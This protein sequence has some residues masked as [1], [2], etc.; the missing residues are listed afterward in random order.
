MIK[1]VKK[2]GRVKSALINWL[3][4]PIELTDDAF[5]RAFTANQ[6]A[7]G[8]TVNDKT[9]LSL[10]AAWACT[11]LIAET[12]STLPLKLYERTSTGRVEATGHS[13]H[14]IL[15][16]RPNSQSTPSTYWEASVAAMLLRGNSFSEKRY[17]GD[18]LVSLQYLQYGRLAPKNRDATVWVYTECDGK[19]RD[20]PASRLFHVP[21][22]SVDGRWGLSAI[23]YGA[24][25]FGSALA[26]SNAANSTFEKGLMP[27]VAFTLDRILKKEQRADF[28][29]SL[30]SM[31][32]ALNA[33]DSPLLEGG[34]DAKQIGIS[35]AD[36][37]LLESRAF[38]VEEVCRWFRV[39]PSM[40]G[41]GGKDSNWGTGLE[42]KVLA[43]LTFTL[44][45]WLTRIE[46]S[47]NKNL[48]TPAEQTRYYA[49][50]SI[51]GLLRADSAARAAF[52]SVLVNN[53]IITR[54]EVRIKEN[55]APRGGNADVLTVQSAM[56]PLDSLG[57]QTD[58]N[59][60]RNAL[61]NWL[62]KE[63]AQ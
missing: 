59:A 39:D 12:A 43:F 36:A 41:H 32:G 4:L 52:Y 3:G 63:D 49:E 8:Q 6:N 34:M 45:P 10:S 53:G 54:D 31:R 61:A 28:R 47:I 7:A 40:V 11:R 29:E 50:F 37:Q 23:S 22:F 56:T 60:A 18:R 30:E 42:Q 19:T 1:N 21:G 16:A 35:P 46:Q 26:S 55:M 17:V 48:L 25:V 62:N 38:S 13:L 57:Q 24:S 44:R 20:I 27:T 14:G 5:W 58:G 33:G 51:E 2:P 9:V 15:H